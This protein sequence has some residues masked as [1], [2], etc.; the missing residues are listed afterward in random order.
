MN[1][2]TLF[3]DI[4]TLRVEISIFDA[5]IRVHFQTRPLTFWSKQI[6]EVQQIEL[7]KF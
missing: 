5:Q 3:V 1:R 4:S 6:L 2:D 7:L